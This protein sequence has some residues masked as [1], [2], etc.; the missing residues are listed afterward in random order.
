[1]A[2]N[3]PRV[4][5]GK[6]GLDGHDRGVRMLA[7]WLRDIG[8]EVVYLGT[9]NTPA[10]VVNAAE[11]EDVDFIGLSFQ[12]AEHVHLLK[13]VKEEMKKAGLDD[14]LLVA[15]G[16][17]PRQDFS[18]LKDIGVDAVCP[19]GSSMQSVTEYFQRW[20]GRPGVS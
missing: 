11:Q 9:H 3:S 19:P 2:K 16:N 10:A 15:G 13:L 17:I 5:L 12:G 20:E 4:L 14:V 1:M 7:A 8:M 18:K 6:V